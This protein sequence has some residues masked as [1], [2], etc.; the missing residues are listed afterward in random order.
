M[1]D[2]W[3]FVGHGAALAAAGAERGW[4][5]EAGSDAAYFYWVQ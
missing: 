4:S 2:I 5:E 3:D 1:D